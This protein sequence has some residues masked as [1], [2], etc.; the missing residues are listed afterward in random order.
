M[1]D[2]F[3]KE[4]SKGFRPA[5]RPRFA[6][7]RAKDHD[8]KFSTSVTEGADAWY[9]DKFA[10]A[11]FFSQELGQA[12]VDAGFATEKAGLGEFTICDIAS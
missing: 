12:L 11:L 2:G 5:G 8:L 6:K 9:D 4:Q 10:S 3:I 1:K 7:M